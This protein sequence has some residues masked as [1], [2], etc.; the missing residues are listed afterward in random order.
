MVAVVVPLGPGTLELGDTPDDFSCEV[1][2]AQVTHEYEE[3]TEQRTR[4]CGD[5]I[6][7]AEE[8]TDGFTA[9]LEN[10]LSGAGLYNYLLTNDLTAVTFKFVPNTAV[11]S[12]TPASWDGTVTLKAP[13]TIGSDEFGAP[14]VSDV[15]WT[16]VG[17][18]A[19]TAASDV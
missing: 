2:G 11:G 5:V 10:D 1:V 17:K 9:S 7:A 12:T 13:S 15:E 18:F 14:I 4:L 19:Y 16:A 8:R 3:I 6:P